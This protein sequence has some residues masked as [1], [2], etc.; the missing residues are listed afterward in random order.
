MLERYGD[1]AKLLAGGQ[2]LIAGLNMRLASPRVLIDLNRIAGL[3]GITVAGGTARIGALTRHRTVEH[4]REI[5]RHLPLLKQA[6]PHVAHT[7]IRNRGT[8]GGSIAFADPA[9]ELPACSIALDAI[10]VL[11]GK[12]GERRVR[13]R[14]FFKGLYETDLKPGEVLIAGEIPVLKAGCCSAFGELTRRS[15]DYAIVGLAA[16]GKLERGVFTDLALAF[17]GVGATPVLAHQAAAAMI[18]KDV[19]AA[20]IAA[21]QARLDRDLTPFDDIYHKAA[22]KMHLARVLL[23]R[24]LNQLVSGDGHAGN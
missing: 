14:E 10:F 21:A 1:D 19:S 5:A 16:H 3:E 23:G 18:G 12:R 17:F 22:T 6:L 20:P 15:G 9:A 24:V 11:A 4:S 2:S 13:A 8:F 7:A